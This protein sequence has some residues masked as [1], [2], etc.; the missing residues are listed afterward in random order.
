[1]CILHSYF[2][3]FNFQGGSDLYNFSTYG[4]LIWERQAS[5]QRLHSSRAPIFWKQSAILCMVLW[6]KNQSIAFLWNISRSSKVWAFWSKLRALSYYSF[7]IKWIAESLSSC[8]I[9][10]TSS[11]KKF[12]SKCCL[13]CI[14]TFINIQLFWIQLLETILTNIIDWTCAIRYLILNCF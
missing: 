13:L 14:L 4:E 1:M 10:G 12:F 2:S 3:L 8:R 6:I 7:E 5:K 9:N 11:I